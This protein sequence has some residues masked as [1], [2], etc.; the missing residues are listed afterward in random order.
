MLSTAVVYVNYLTGSDRSN[1]QERALYQRT[2]GNLPEANKHAKL[3]IHFCM[4][5]TKR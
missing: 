3:K 1:S 5:K 2:A 4:C